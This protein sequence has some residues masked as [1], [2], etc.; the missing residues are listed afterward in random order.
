MSYFD[1][2]S[3]NFLTENNTSVSQKI[4]VENN[5]SQLLFTFEEKVS[6]PELFI[7]VT[8]CHSLWENPKLDTSGHF[9][10]TMTQNTQQT[11]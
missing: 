5:I 9:S 10:T 1:S 8:I 11:C 3:K 4:I 2:T 6:R 7:P